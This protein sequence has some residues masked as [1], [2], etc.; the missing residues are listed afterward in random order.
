FSQPRA[1]VV[2]FCTNPT[3]GVERTRVTVTFKFLSLAARSD[4]VIESICQMPEAVSLRSGLDARIPLVSTSHPMKNVL[5][6]AALAFL[7]PL[8]HAQAPAAS[9]TVD[10]SAALEKMDASGKFQWMHA[11]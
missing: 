4:S 10:A 7:S 6:F 9:P 8:L 3:P 11:S 2:P 1:R 5:L